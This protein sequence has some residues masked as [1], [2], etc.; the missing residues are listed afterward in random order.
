MAWF[1]GQY[2]NVCV[3]VYKILQVL[4]FYLMFNVWHRSL[5]LHIP[6]QVREKF[7][8]S[9]KLSFASTAKVQ[10]LRLQEPKKGIR[11]F[12]VQDICKIVPV[13]K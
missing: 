1:L 7:S 6:F 12:I 10:P 13:L 5:N 2:Q 8:S 11:R 4:A 3:Q 9:P